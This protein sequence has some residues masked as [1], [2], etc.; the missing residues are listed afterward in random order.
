LTRAVAVFISVGQMGEDVVQKLQQIEGI[1]I[2][3]E[4]VHVARDGRFSEKM[5]AVFTVFHNHGV[6]V[7]D[8]M[9]GHG[10]LEGLFLKLTKRKLRDED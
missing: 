7:K 5:A 3:K 8:V 1:K 6:C 9:F 4:G 2:E 10:T